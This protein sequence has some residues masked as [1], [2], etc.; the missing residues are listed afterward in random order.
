MDTPCQRMSDG[1][2]KYVEM[3]YQRCTKHAVYVRC[4]N[5]KCTARFN[6]KVLSPLIITGNSKETFRINPEA[7]EAVLCNTDNFK[8]PEHKCRH[9]CE[10]TEDDEGF[11]NVSRHLP[12]CFTDEPAGL[13]VINK[14]QLFNLFWRAVSGRAK[15]CPASCFH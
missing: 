13:E 12:A 10:G 7:P 3:S 6:L 1:T 8:H 4:A 11:C 14:I 2:T 5:R 9:Y 15:I